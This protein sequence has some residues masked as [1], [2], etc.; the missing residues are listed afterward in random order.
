MFQAPPNQIELQVAGNIAR[1][2]ALSA[3]ITYLEIDGVVAIAQVTHEAILQSFAS[4]VCAPWPNRIAKGVWRNVKFPGND[5]HGNAL[6]GLVFDKEFSLTE[7]SDDSV[8]Y[9]YKLQATENYPFDLEI[10]ARYVL[11]ADGLTATYFAKNVGEGNAPYGV[12]AHPYFNVYPESTFSFNAETQAINNDIQIPVGTEPNNKVQGAQV[13]SEANLDDCFSELSGNVTIQHPDGG[14]VTIWQDSA[15][16]YLM[17]YTGHHLQKY[18]FPNAGLAIEPQTCPADAF[19]TGEDLIWLAAG[20]Y[21]SAN[22]GIS[23][24]GHHG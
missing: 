8:T 22:W 5:P 20:Q 18:G 12:A 15:F 2:S 11:S 21:W 9:L 16:K 10:G 19:N 1:F 4:V 24:K 23:A 14:E 3:A 6:H 17:V 7:Q 13:F